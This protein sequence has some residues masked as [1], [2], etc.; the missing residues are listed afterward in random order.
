M[1]ELYLSFNGITEIGGLEKLKKLKILDLAHNRIATLNAEAFS[2][3]QEE[4]EDLWLND[5]KIESLEDACTVVKAFAK[6][7]TV[8][9]EANL[10][11]N[12]SYRIEL[13][14]A[15][16]GLVQIDADDVSDEERA[17]ANKQ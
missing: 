17:L 12:P 9:L 11:V 15:R 7:E 14:K 16:P 10:I 1:Q 2:G 6:L 3:Q 8:Y 13:V 4:L 5:N